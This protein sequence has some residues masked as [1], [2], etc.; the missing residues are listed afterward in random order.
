M[1]KVLVLSA[2]GK[3]GSTVVR[4]LL[5][6]EFQTSGPNS[7]RA[8]VRDASSEKAKALSA[9]GAELVEGGNWDSDVA[10][11][12]RAFA[13]GI[14]AV[15]FVSIPSFTDFDA[16]N[17]G[18]TN[19]I[20]AAKRAGT[21][22]HVVYS[23]VY[24]AENYKELPGWDASPVFANYW[25][26]K[27]KSEE[28]VKNAGFP[29]Y[30]ILRPAEFMSNYTGSTA[31]IQ[32]PDLVKEGVWHTPF[33]PS[34]SLSLIDEHDI[35]RTTAASIISPST[36]PASESGPSHEL[37]LIGERITVGEVLKHL[38]AA[39]GKDL[40]ISTLTPEEAVKVA[41]QNP[42][43][44]GQVLRIKAFEKG[45]TGVAPAE[46]FGLGFRTFEEHT[47]VRSEEIKE[48]YKNTP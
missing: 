21:V 11:L 6:P 13:G 48:V 24:G 43:V 34:F 4:A 47:K 30:T 37:N 9:L 18:A 29:H 28:L 39:A 20:E 45:A 19:V 15:F 26:A 1:V 17:R 16:E 3:Q 25:I 38:S 2:T 42:I 46:S 40:K 36:F 12:D 22:K 7:V 27:A 31:S 44:A 5:S 8:Y 41:E 35:G 32:I 14:E 33:S 10:S 23:N